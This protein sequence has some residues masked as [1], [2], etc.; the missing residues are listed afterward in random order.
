MAEQIHQE[1][2]FDFNSQRIYDAL[3]DAKQFAELTDS[4]TEINS[5]PGGA[6]SC[7]GGMI[8]G[9]TIELVPGKRIVQAW[10]VGNWAP[11]IYSIIKFEL[12]ELNDMETKLIFDQAGFPED[13]RE[14][15]A[16]GWHDRY[17]N[18]LKKFLNN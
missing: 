6:F 2:L 5:E 8:T 17:W 14:H 7:F 10:R 1:I 15:L 4:K 3:T 11:G 13:N 18:P 16:Q 12:E 9:R